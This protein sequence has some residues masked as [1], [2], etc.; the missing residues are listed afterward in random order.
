MKILQIITSPNLKS[1]VGSLSKKISDEVIKKYNDASIESLV[2]DE[3]K[4]FQETLNANSFSSFFDD[5]TNKLIE[6]LNETDLIIISTPTINFGVPSVLKN[7]FDRVLQAGKT[8][9]YKY[10]N[11]K[12]GS[13]GLLKPNK[14]VLIIN[15]QGSP[16]NWYPFTSVIDQIK[17][18]FNFIGVKDVY[19]LVVDGTKT[20]EFINKTHEEIIELNKKKIDK[21]LSKLNK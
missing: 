1:Q 19:S 15:T 7:Y 5:R 12:G 9:K 18:S 17:G 11:G 8:F 16:S 14:K 21:V 10:D 13:V 20:P 2:L 3:D 4:Y 6:Q